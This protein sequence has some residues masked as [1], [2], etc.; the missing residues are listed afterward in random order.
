MEL[1]VF[2]SAEFGS[3][4]TTTVNGEVTVKTATETADAGVVK[5]CKNWNF[6]FVRVLHR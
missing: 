1:Q 3:V 2:S 5:R 6:W 4:R